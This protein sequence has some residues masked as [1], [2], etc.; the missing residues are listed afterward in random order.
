MK[1][2]PRSLGGY[3]PITGLGRSNMA[4]GVT[5]REKD[6][7]LPLFMSLVKLKRDRVGVLGSQ[8][9]T[10]PIIHLK[11]IMGWVIAQNHM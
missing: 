2:N 11:L 10:L 3:N 5:S 7:Y 1:H 6:I 9:V 8:I 4:V